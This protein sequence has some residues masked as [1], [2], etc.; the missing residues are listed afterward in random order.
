MIEGKVKAPDE[1][2]LATMGEYL[3]QDLNPMFLSK[4]LI[5]PT[6]SEIMNELKVVDPEKIQSVRFLMRRSFAEKYREKLHSL[7]NELKDERT[8]DLSDEQMGKRALKNTLLGYLALTP[9]SGEARQQYRHADNFT[10]KLGALS[11]MV[12]D[13]L[14]GAEWALDDF[15]KRYENDAIPL[16]KWFSVQAIMPVSETVNKVKQLLK[17]PKFDMKMPSKVGALL[18]AFTQNLVAFNSKEGYQLMAEQIAE[19]DKINSQRAAVLAESFRSIKKM[20]PALFESAKKALTRLRETAKLSD[21][22]REIVGK[23]LDA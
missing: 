2:L 6:N 12:H 5:L 22:T 7:Y 18:G 15:Y 1:E 19:L 17:H 10:E 9:Y 21:S 20:A 14:E 13:Q 23:I 3:N 8:F 11:V 4:A 16:N